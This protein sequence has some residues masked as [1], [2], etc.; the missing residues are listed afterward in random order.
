VEIAIDAVNEGNANFFTQIK[1]GLEKSWKWIVNK[2]K[3]AWN[4]FK[5]KFL[6]I[7]EKIINEADRHQIDH[8]AEASFEQ[9]LIAQQNIFSFL[10]KLNVIN[11][12]TVVANFI[13]FNSFFTSKI[14]SI[15]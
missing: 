2:T 13:L 8:L 15:S 7:C 9:L 1:T 12:I 3:D 5:D 10:I 4:F 6:W 11:I 14:V